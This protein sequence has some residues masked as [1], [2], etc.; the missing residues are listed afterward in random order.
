MRLNLTT[1]KEMKPDMT[2]S[3][4]INDI[5]TKNNEKETNDTLIR[6][7]IIDK[8]TGKYLK[9]HE[10]NG[11]FGENLDVYKIDSIKS[12]GYDTDFIEL[13]GITGI[14]IT[15]SNRDLAMFD[16]HGECG[17][18]FSYEQL[19]QGEIIDYIDYNFYISQYNQITNTLKHIMN[20]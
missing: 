13:Y 1:L 17:N 9:I 19:E 10:P 14:K 2:I 8:Y 4:L 6:K 12:I 16:I 7:Q 5:E 20:G 3:E 11:I 18:S 15:F